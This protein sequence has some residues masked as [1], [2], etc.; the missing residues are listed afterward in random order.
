MVHDKVFI[1]AEA[2]VNHNGNYDRAFELID[3]AAE[4]CVDAIKFQTFNTKHL[5]TRNAFKAPYQVTKTGKNES[6]YQMLA[7]LELSHG[8]HRK[9]KA[10]SERKGLQFMST[11]FDLVS[12]EFLVTD[13]QLE[14]LKIPSGELTNGPLLL[15]YGQSG[16]DLILSTGMSTTEE[17]HEALMLVSFGLSGG[18]DP[19]AEKNFELFDWRTKQGLLRSKVLL[20][21]CTSQYPAPAHS[22]NLHAISTMMDEYGLRVGYSDHSE[23]ITIA[24]AAVALG[25]RVIEKHFTLDKTLPGPDHSASLEPRELQEMVKAIR[26]IEK[27]LGD[28]VKKPQEAER[29]NREASRKSL[30]AA[31]DI[32]EGETFTV[33]NIVAKRPGTGRSPMSYWSVL[34]TQA[35]KQY[36]ADDLI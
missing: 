3:V 16:R 10:Y 12:L 21:H 33:A 30:V 1:I 4:S 15:A 22:I 5:V 20:L 9:L 13:L 23:G 11:A 18:T 14:L 35:K 28:G 24:C 7:N 26:S 29:E 27:A 19:T 34:G 32:A 2:G 25:A 31:K 36:K 8:V 6:Q 17:V